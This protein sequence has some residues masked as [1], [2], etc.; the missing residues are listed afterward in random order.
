MNVSIRTKKR[1]PQFHAL[2]TL[3]F[4]KHNAVNVYGR[5][6]SAIW[7][8]DEKWIWKIGLCKMTGERQNQTKMKTKKAAATQTRNNCRKTANKIDEDKKIRTH[9]CSLSLSRVTPID[10]T[11]MICIRIACRIT[12]YGRCV[13]QLSTSYRR[14]LRKTRDMLKW[15]SVEDSA[16]VIEANRLVSGLK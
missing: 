15:A 1:H 7:S 13:D 14:L 9:L 16:S 6:Y 3:P 8:S 12:L 4:G 11:R 10:C 2:E 5:F